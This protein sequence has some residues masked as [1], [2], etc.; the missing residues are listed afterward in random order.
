MNFDI[1]YIYLVVEYFALRH[2]R[3]SPVARRVHWLVREK[4]GIERRRVLAR[5]AS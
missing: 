1:H 5:R 2:A 4:L 3:P